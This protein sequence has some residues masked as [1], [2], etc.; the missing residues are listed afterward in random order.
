MTTF[1]RIIRNSSKMCNY[2]EIA[3]AKIVLLLLQLVTFVS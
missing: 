2:K 3:V 1:T